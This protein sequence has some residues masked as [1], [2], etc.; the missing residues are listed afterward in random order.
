MTLRIDVSASSLPAPPARYE[1]LAEIEPGTSSR[2][3]LAIDRHAPQ[4]ARLVVVHMVH[5]SIA[6][7]RDF[8]AAFGNSAT[9]S[10]RL[11]HPNIVRTLDLAADDDSCYWVT[12]FVQGRTLANVLEKCSRGE[13]RR[14]LGRSRAAVQALSRTRYLLILREV[15]LGLEYAHSLVG[16][17]GLRCPVFHRNLCPSSVLI[18]YDGAV[19]ISDYAL[20]VAPEVTFGRLEGAATRLAYFAPERCLGRPSDSRCDVYAVG[21]M[22]WEVLANR[23]RR[24]GNNL[25]EALEI[26]LRDADPKLEDVRPDVPPALAAMTERALS[27]Q[28]QDRYQ[29]AREFRLELDDHLTK[30]GV[31][32][33]QG[34]LFGFM[35]NHFREE[36]A[37]MEALLDSRA[38]ELTRREPALARALLE[39]RM[40]RGD[41]GAEAPAE[42]E[43]RSE[44]SLVAFV[45]LKDNLISLSPE[46][47]KWL[48]RWLLPCAAGVAVALPLL[49]WKPASDPPAPPST[50]ASAASAAAPS[51]PLVSAPASTAAWEEPTPHE[52]VTRVA[53]P[54]L[55]TPEPATPVVTRAELSLRDADSTA[56]PQSPATADVRADGAPADR[57]PEVAEAAPSAVPSAP[58]L[59]SARAGRSTTRPA[60]LASRSRAAEHA[61][62]SETSGFEH[63]GRRPNPLDDED[64]A[65]SLQLPDDTVVSA[66]T[67]L[68]ALRR[69]VARP[70]DRKDPYS[71]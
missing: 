24:S 37:T 48:G 34:L 30:T 61:G 52:R 56:E 66:G 21:G 39:H 8:R 50:R 63:D 55:A 18:A 59:D 19:K 15:L 69:H 20:G 64:P 32:T 12:E 53:T 29:S 5:R 43:R 1:Y 41:G 28:P 4:G 60:R 26:R 36:Y 16:S 22:L 7:D 54:E 33:D 42:P 38:A 57:L 44:G 67:N 47:R 65:T 71:P 17:S 10:Q 13:S 9:V 3:Y 51:D 58:A 14:Y 62:P 23:P 68:R 45:Q 11:S 6:K 40:R 25:Q 2:A 27:W 70:I 31:R 46:R 49:L 35:S